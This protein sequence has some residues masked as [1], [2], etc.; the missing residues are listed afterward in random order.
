MVEHHL[1]IQHWRIPVEGR[2]IN[3]RAIGNELKGFPDL[4]ICYRGYF[5]GAEAKSTA[6]TLS[7][8]QTVMHKRIN[9][10]D[11]FAFVFR[12]IDELILNLQSTV[13]LRLSPLTASQDL[14]CMFEQRDRMFHENKQIQR[15]FGHL[16]ASGVASDTDSQSEFVPPF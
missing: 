12:S 2:R 6:G 5:V 4:L 3:G 13:G 16:Q 1:P 8:E 15:L 14:V 9:D 10:A 7:T 11:G